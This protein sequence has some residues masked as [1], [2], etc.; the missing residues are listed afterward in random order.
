MR[1]GRRADDE[2]NPECQHGQP[3]TGGDVLT[4]AETVAAVRS[5]GRN[6]DTRCPAH[7]DARA[8]LSVGIGESGMVLFHCQAGC[9]FEDVVDASGLDRA[10]LSAPKSRRPSDV[11]RFEIMDSDR[12]VVAIHE[13]IDQ[14]PGR[15]KFVWRQPDGTAGLNG[16]R[17]ADLP[18]YKA[19]QLEAGVPV[20]VCEGEGAA[21]SLLSR[22]YA[23]VGTVTGAGGCPSDDSL[24][25][26]L[27]RTVYL[28]PDNDAPGAAHVQRIAARLAKLGADDVRIVRWAD[29]PEHAD[30]ADFTGD[31]QALLGQAQ[32]AGAPP[33]ATTLPVRTPAEIATLTEERPKAYA[34]YIFANAVT[35]F[36]G[37]AKRG[38][39]SFLLY[40]VGCIVHLLDCL[41]EP[42]IGTGV[43]YLTEERAT[44]MRAALAR[45]GLLDAPRLHIVSRWD[46]PASMSWPE[47]IQAAV[48]TCVSTSSKVVIVDTFPAW[49][50]LRGESENN[51]GD[52]LAALE[53]CQ[54]AAANDL[55]WVIVQ[56][57]RKGGGVVGE[58]GR[59]SSAF[60]GAVDTILSLRRPEGHSNPNQRVLEAIS[61]F[62]GVPE[63]VLIERAA[64]DSFSHIPTGSRFG[65][66]LYRALGEPGAVEQR[67]TERAVMAALEVGPLAMDGLKS[68]LPEHK[69]TTIVRALDALSTGGSVTRSGAGKK[70]SPYLYQRR[71]EVS[72]QTSNPRVREEKKPSGGDDAVF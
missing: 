48:E 60:A 11:R 30:A 53:P 27:E 44:T 71:A 47:T 16:R 15:K 50:G 25:P 35:M 39:T 49:A 42:T 9:A 23:A 69:P 56:H 65:K 36:T 24:R 68:A 13:R 67:K 40:L 7:K 31:V 2:C 72:F 14:S 21:D 66:N 20:I 37:Y 51:A 41:G 33:A 70:G 17:V 46:V 18:L 55:A 5:D 63:A 32:P 58:S 22:G 26:L 64:E 57:D 61:R 59:G 43:V 19:H 38:K 28:W 29:A 3:E 4:L 10:A 1:G 12:K 34:P 54:R 62:D 8:S 52:V 45:T 6:R